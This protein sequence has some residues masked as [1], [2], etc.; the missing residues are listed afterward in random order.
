[1]Q[2]RIGVLIAVVST[3]LTCLASAQN[4]L[5]NGD[6]ESNPPKPP[7]AS[8]PGCFGNNIG[9]SITPWM[10]G[11]GNQSNVVKVDGGVHPY[12]SSAEPF[13]GPEVDASAP[14]VGIPQHYLDIAGGSNDFYQS[15]TPQCS[16]AVDFGGSFTTRDNHASTKTSVAIREGVGTLGN[17]VG[18]TQPINLPAGNS[19]SD[20]WVPVTFTVPV[21]ANVTYSFV[22]S[23]DNNANFD[24]GFVKFKVN[25]DT[26]PVDPCCPPWNS[27]TLK[28]SL[29]YQSSGA[30]ADPYTLVFRPSPQLLAQMQAYINYL[31]SVNPAITQITIEFRLH[32]A[33][34]GATPVTGQQVGVSHFATWSESGSGIVN[35][36]V[37]F[38]TPSE[39]MLVGRWYTI[40]TGIFL[41]NGQA[42]FPATCAVNE[43]NVRV[44]VLGKLSRGIAGAALQFRDWDGTI[45][46]RALSS[47]SNP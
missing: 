39:A 16:G 29:F 22:V 45:V 2:F 7:C 14:G 42:F 19:N 12:A 6:F 34:I 15:F 3:M 25:C 11:P 32:D 10:L 36:S 31:H 23:M 18:S 17:V 9:H 13:R 27:A 21:T 43:I 37:F 47:I 44:Q 4:I 20:P 5:V 24:N 8:P 33:G 41:E 46:T 38:T 28:K 40:H 35:P 1:M 30:I 26:P